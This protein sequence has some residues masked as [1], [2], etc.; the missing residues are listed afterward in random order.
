VDGKRICCIKTSL[1][2]EALRLG[3]LYE[4]ELFFV[5]SFLYDSNIFFT[6]DSALILTSFVGFEVLIA[7]IMNKKFWE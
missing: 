6:I 2:S 7:A 5:K 4:K 1:S 3:S